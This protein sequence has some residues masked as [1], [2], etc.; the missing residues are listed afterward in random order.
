MI[1][2][3]IDCNNF[4]V[5]CERLFK[6]CLENKPVVVLSNN[7]G[8]VI[9]RS[10]E[11]KSLG[12]AM[13]EPFFQVKE[14]CKVHGVVVFSS[15][16]SLYGSLSS[17]VMSLLGEMGE[18]MEI[19]SIDEAFITFENGSEVEL[20]T[21]AEKLRTQIKQWVGIPVS[22]GI[23]KTK[24]LAKIASEKAKKD[25]KGVFSLLDSKKKEV[26]LKDFQVEEIWGIARGG[27]ARLN[28]LGIFTAWEF[29]QAE[30]LLIRKKMGVVGER[31]LLELQDTSCLKLEEAKSKKSITCSRSF[32][33]PL[34]CFDD[35]AEALSHFV[36]NACIK[37]RKEQLLCSALAVFVETYHK[38]QRVPYSI[39]IDLPFPTNDTVQ[40]ITFA[41]KLLK[42]LFKEN[43][44]YKKCG[45]IL[46]NLTSEG[47]V[48]YDLFFEGHE[49]RK[50][51]MQHI[52]HLN[53]TFGKNTL[54]FGA[55]GVNLNWKMKA[56]KRSSEYMENWD[57]L[58]TVRS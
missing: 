57:Q 33:K 54:F 51:L 5:S 29:H 21:L 36:N 25:P 18:E 12:I 40:C 43:N 15:N 4:F 20:F 38:G 41:K 49:K 42:K 9:A 16:F 27:K 30:S 55:M 6:P 39:T 19:Y 47:H 48:Q 50:K 22:I 58:P 28:A 17:R 14:L 31:I 1:Y 13:G 24:T 32:G 7:D 23:A 11:A 34:S 45:V 56:H 53:A 44:V 37:L 8:C 3:L 35:I 52:D 46:L 2:F 26:I 10:Q